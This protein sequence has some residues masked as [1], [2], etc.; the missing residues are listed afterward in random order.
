MG[1]PGEDVHAGSAVMGTLGR[2]V[3]V[4]ARLCALPG[5]TTASM[6]LGPVMSPNRATMVLFFSQYVTHTL[7]KS[8]ALP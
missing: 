6:V 3:H 1:E 4:E 5:S 2:E 7:R 8:V